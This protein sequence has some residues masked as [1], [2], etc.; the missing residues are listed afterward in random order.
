MTAFECFSSGISVLLNNVIP[1]ASVNIILNGAI[2]IADSDNSM[3]EPAII[4]LHPFKQI[5]TGIG[6]SSHA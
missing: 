5:I 4:L 2:E 1:K 3:Q 6:M